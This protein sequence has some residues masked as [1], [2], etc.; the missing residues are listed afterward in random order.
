M[1]EELNEKLTASKIEI[2]D[3][4]IAAQ[5]D[6]YVARHSDATCFHLYGWRQAL[7]TTLG[8]ETRYFGAIQDGTL[9]GILPV[10][11]VSSRL[12]GTS[13]V[14]LPFCTYGGAVSDDLNIT[15]QLK[16]AAMEFAKSKGAGFFESRVVG[17]ASSPVQ[18]HTYFTFRKAIPAGTAEM[19]FMPSKR[20]NMVRKAISAGLSWDV[21]RDLNKFFHLYAENARA[22]GTPALPKQFFACLLESLGNAV[23]ILFVYDKGGRPISCIMSFFDKGIVHA[24][25]AGEIQ[26]ARELAANDFKYWSLYQ[27]AKNRDCTVF[28]LG[29]SKI[30]TGSY[31]FKKLWGLEPSPITHEVHLIAMKEKPKNNPNNP[32]FALAIK[33]WAKLPRFV[34]DRLGPSIIHGLG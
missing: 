8:Y 17:S 24:G 27:F 29:R 25:F 4:R 16:D 28:D 3:V 5:W 7:E 22:H 15:T 23:D 19:T 11:F 10:A 33:V 12:F 31:D 21:S 34:V 6:A 30:N 13:L 32:K 14:S 2:I 18:E 26:V 20:R 1:I 9:V